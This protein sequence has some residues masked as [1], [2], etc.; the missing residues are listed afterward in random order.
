[1]SDF[2]VITPLNTATISRSPSYSKGPQVQAAPDALASTPVDAYGYP[3]QKKKSHWFLKTLAA[4]AVLG[5]TAAILRKKVDV[6]KNFD[7]A[8]AKLADKASL[9]EKA[10]FYGTKVVSYVGE[11]VNQGVDYVVR[12]FKGLGEGAEKTAEKT[13][14]KAAEKAT[15]AA[16]A[17]TAQ[18]AET[19][20]EK[21]A[22]ATAQAAAK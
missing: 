10:K 8:G 11:K 12:L 6:F 5:T 1:M 14:E 18:A 9:T 7:L 15:E 2:S 13:T 4:V 19:T 16:T 21:A 20:A 17:A 22:E 3:Q